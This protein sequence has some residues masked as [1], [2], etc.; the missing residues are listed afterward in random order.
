MHPQ[1]DAAHRQSRLKAAEQLAA[2]QANLLRRS[3][4]TRLGWTDG[5]VDHEIKYGRWSVPAR[6][7]VSLHNVPIADHQRTWLGVLYAGN[8]AVVSHLTVLRGLGLKW[9]APDVIDIL[10]PRG[11]FI[12]SLPGFHFHQTRRRFQ[13]WLRPVDEGPPRLPIEHAALL[14]AERQPSAR[15][16]IEVLAR[17]VQQGLTTPERL[18]CTMPHIRKLRHGSQFDLAL[19]D[20]AGGA[21]SFAEIDLATLCKEAGLMLPTRQAVRRDKEGRRRFLDFEW[22]LPSGEV[23]VLE[24][25]GAFHMDVDNW[26]KD[27][28]RERAIA[29][30]STTVLRCAS[31][32]LRL[33]PTDILQ[34]LRRAGVPYRGLVIAS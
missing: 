7:V 23:I 30:E 16:G 33:T 11:D 21:Q 13:S 14:T 22:R 26:W 29:T 6:G 20:I 18:G 17:C 1:R 34:D 25:D 9:T 19:G 28:R 5:Q 12:P 2:D 3:Q 8:E 4:L 31:V 10:T 27:M 15:A 32:E 24:V